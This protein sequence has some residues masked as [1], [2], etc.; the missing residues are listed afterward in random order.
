MSQAA[1]LCR[2]WMPKMVS[3]SA[4]M[5]KSYNSQDLKTASLAAQGH[6]HGLSDPRFHDVFVASFLPSMSTTILVALRGACVGLRDL[7][8]SQATSHIWSGA[9]QR[10]LLNEPSCNCPHYSPH[11]MS[12]STQK[13][14]TQSAA[15]LLSMQ[16]GCSKCV[17]SELRCA[18]KAAQRLMAGHGRI[19]HLQYQ[20]EQAMQGH[21][22]N[23]HKYTSADWSQCGRWIAATKRVRTSLDLNDI[24]DC[25]S[26]S[27]VA[28]IDTK[29]DKWTLIDCP[30]SQI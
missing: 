15:D 7:I 5:D 26:D 12:G 4:K 9:A 11:Q 10:H 8:D 21:R 18:G 19:Q 24:A 27:N 16:P 20:S 2:L 1:C 28:V 22:Y 17:Q 23:L 30:F 6:G 25:P 13:Q 3:G 14:P 29:N